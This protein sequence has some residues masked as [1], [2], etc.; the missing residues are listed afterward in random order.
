[1]HLEVIVLS[2]LNAVPLRSCWLVMHMHFKALEGSSLSAVVR[3]DNVS[4]LVFLQIPKS[5]MDVAFPLSV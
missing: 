5:I 3:A 4:N 1:M 2:K